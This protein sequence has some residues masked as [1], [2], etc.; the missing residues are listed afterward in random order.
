VRKKFRQHNRQ[1]TRNTKKQTRNKKKQT[2]HKLKQHLFAHI[3][4]VA[5][6]RIWKCGGTGPARKWGHRSG[7]KCRKKF[8]WVVHLHFFGL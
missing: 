7:A 6:E 4:S 2:R 1:Q 8:F 5:A 3:L